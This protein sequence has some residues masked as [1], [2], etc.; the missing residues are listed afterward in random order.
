MHQV[1]LENTG[2]IRFIKTNPGTQLT[3]S[4]N[5]IIEDP[6]LWY[7]EENFEEIKENI[8]KSMM[9]N[10]FSSMRDNN[11]EYDLEILD[12][13]FS[14]YPDLLDQD[15]QKIINTTQKFCQHV[16]KEMIKNKK[17][18]KKMTKKKNPKKKKRNNRIKAINSS[19]EEIYISDS[20][21]EKMKYNS[22]DDQSISEDSEEPV[23]H[24]KKKKKSKLES[25]D[26][27]EEY[28]TNRRRRR[29]RRN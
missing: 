29:K 14:K 1:N 10:I 11:F 13:E 8:L 19:E 22:I 9:L 24:R 18:E 3:S 15:R 2:P 23:I 6:I 20:E 12:R 25:I 5:P 16:N 27:S 4:F 7:G 17:A 26:S 28:V 21:S